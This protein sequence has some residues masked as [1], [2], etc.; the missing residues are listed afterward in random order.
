M[1]EVGIAVAMSAISELGN[2][3]LEPVSTASWRVLPKLSTLDCASDGSC[4]CSC[5]SEVVEFVGAARAP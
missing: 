1:E 2:V 3:G 4:A 5:S